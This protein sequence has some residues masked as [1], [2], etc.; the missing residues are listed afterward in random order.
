MTL[1]AGRV[2]FYWRCLFVSRH[3]M[4]TETKDVLNCCRQCGGPIKLYGLADSTRYSADDDPSE[5]PEDAS[6]ASTGP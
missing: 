5:A 6:D 2:R 3:T 4:E 1:L